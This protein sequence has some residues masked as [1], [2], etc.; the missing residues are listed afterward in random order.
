MVNGKADKTERPILS[1][2]FYYIKY[3]NAWKHKKRFSSRGTV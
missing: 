1:F 3:F 2:Q